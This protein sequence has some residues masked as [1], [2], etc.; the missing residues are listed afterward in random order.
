MKNVCAFGIVMVAVFGVMA[1][2]AWAFKVGDPAE[3]EWN[4]QCFSATVKQVN[5]RIV[6]KW[7][8]GTVRKNGMIVGQVEAAGTIR[9]DGSIWGSVSCEGS[10]YKSVRRAS[11]VI[12]FFSSDFGF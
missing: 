8:S 3:V 7:D 6:G 4:G 2:A 11:A 1:G 5:G 9:K 10:D 12:A